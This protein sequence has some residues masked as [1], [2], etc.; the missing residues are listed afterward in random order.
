M[1]DIL[2]GC[3][4]YSI[5]LC[6]TEFHLCIIRS[7]FKYV[8]TGSKDEFSKEQLDFFPQVELEWHKRDIPI[9]VQSKCFCTEKQ[10]VQY[11]IPHW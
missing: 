5:T 10:M 11:F 9:I 4:S 6:G 3:K 8:V 7:A 2:T 1:C